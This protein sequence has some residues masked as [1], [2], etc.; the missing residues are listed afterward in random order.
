MC[1]HSPPHFPT[2]LSPTAQRSL[3]FCCI[4]LSCYRSAPDALMLVLLPKAQSN[5]LFMD[6]VASLT[7]GLPKKC[8][9]TPASTRTLTSV[10]SVKQG[11]EGLPCKVQMHTHAHTTHTHTHTHTPV[12][13]DHTAKFPW[14]S[15]MDLLVFSLN[16]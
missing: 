12:I 6:S 11:Q 4:H 7:S 16:C 9:T 14:I 3:T 1:V 10:D 15:I 13:S 2:A 8:P 5:P